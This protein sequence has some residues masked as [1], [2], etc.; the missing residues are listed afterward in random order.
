MFLLFSILW[1]KLQSMMHFF[2]AKFIFVCISVSLFI[3]YYIRHENRLSLPADRTPIIAGGT[4]LWMSLSKSGRAFSWNF[5]FWS[6]CWIVELVTIIRKEKV[7]AKTAPSQNLI[8]PCHWIQ[9]RPTE[10]VRDDNDASNSRVRCPEVGETHTVSFWSVGCLCQWLWMHA[11]RER[12]IEFR[13]IPTAPKFLTSFWSIGCFGRRWEASS[14]HI[15]FFFLFLTK[16]RWWRVFLIV[17][18]FLQGI[19][20]NLT[21]WKR[22]YNCSSGCPERFVFSACTSAKC[23]AWLSSSEKTNPIIWQKKTKVCSCRKNLSMSPSMPITQ[24][25]LL[26]EQQLRYQVCLCVAIVVGWRR[27][28]SLHRNDVSRQRDHIV[29]SNN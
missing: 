19:L 9:K 10:S 5:W 23:L 3:K 14:R 20:L 26:D 4:L 13:E 28:V 6:R 16:N 25:S 1:R 27:G 17:Q 22:L 21:T 8:G 18:K 12:C 29:F 7:D 11:R 2:I 24:V 15:N